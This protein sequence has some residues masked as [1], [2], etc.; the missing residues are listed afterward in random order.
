MAM[1][2]TTAASGSLRSSSRRRRG[3]RARGQSRIRDD[4]AQEVLG[5]AVD[6]ERLA[7]G[8]GLEA[9]RD[10]GGGARPVAFG[11]AP[12]AVRL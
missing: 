11:G 4:V 10:E 5:H 7:D 8:D 1:S 12:E 3:P 6:A 2:C 9:G